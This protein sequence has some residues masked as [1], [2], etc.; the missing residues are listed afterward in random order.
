MPCALASFSRR[1]QEVEGNGLQVRLRKHASNITEIALML[2]WQAW[3]QIP[4]P[5]NGGL[6]ASLANLPSPARPNQTRTLQQRMSSSLRRLPSA[7]YPA[8]TAVCRPVGTLPER[9]ALC[10]KGRLCAAKSFHRAS[11]LR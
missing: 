9:P 7:A 4:I 3:R 5:S 8:A 2:T 10:I 1:S 11:S 6:S